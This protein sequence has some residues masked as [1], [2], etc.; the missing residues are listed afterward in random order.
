MNDEDETVFPQDSG[1]VIGDTISL[2]V[3]EKSC[4]TYQIKINNNKEMFEW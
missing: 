4:K 1:A 2:K 3:C